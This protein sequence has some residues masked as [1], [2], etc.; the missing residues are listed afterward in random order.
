MPYHIV[1][2]Q[3]TSYH[4]VDWYTILYYSLNLPLVP[5]L[6]SGSHCLKGNLSNMWNSLT[7]PSPPADRNKFLI[8]DNE[9][10]KN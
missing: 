10:L 3:I 6:G 4:M 5:G 8:E 1:S 9:K 2:N 7:D